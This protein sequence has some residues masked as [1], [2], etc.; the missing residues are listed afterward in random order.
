MTESTK[1]E[2]EIT[3]N[4][5]YCVYK[6]DID[7]PSDVSIADVARAICKEFNCNMSKGTYCGDPQIEQHVKQDNDIEK[8]INKAKSFI[9]VLS[10]MQDHC[11]EQLT[12]E[13]AFNDKGEDMLFDYIY[14]SGED[15]LYLNFEEWLSFYKY[16]TKDF[17]SK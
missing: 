5:R 2:W 8:R 17:L 9:N 6:Y 16:K 4:D 7:I 14:N 11:F 10:K 15:G 13:L 12:S 1:K 3:I